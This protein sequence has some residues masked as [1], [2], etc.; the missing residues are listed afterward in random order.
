MIAR[1]AAFVPKSLRTWFTIHFL[2]DLSLALPLLVAPQAMLQLF[3]WESIDPVAT[4]LVAAAML[5]IG[6]E[7]WL[8]RNGSADAYRSLLRLKIIWSAAA[9]AGLAAS[10]AL[11]APVMAVAFLAI[12]AAFLAL[13]IHY[14]CRMTIWA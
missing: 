9:C 11:G 10:L 13:W 14:Y 6:G 4:R 12:F 7:S 2:L 5:A 1:A 8:G 3:G